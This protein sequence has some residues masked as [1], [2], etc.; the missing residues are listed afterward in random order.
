MNPTI[1][2]N[3]IRLVS[4]LFLIGFLAIPATAYF[5]ANW[6]PATLFGFVGIVCNLFGT[7]WIASGVYM[8]STDVKHLKNGNKN[9]SKLLSHIGEILTSASRVIPWGIAYIVLGSLYQMLA[10]IGVQLKWFGS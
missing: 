4:L 3:P 2:K 10:L 1:D 5:K 8:F 9:R 7:L 6:S